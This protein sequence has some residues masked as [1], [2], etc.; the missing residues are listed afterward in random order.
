MLVSDAVV[1]AWFSGADK[2]NRSFV[3]FSQDAGRTFGAP[4]RLDEGGSLGRVD[5]ALLDD[6]SAVASWIEFA[7]G[8]AEFRYRRVSADGRSGPALTVTPM[9]SDRSAG[10]PR[11]AQHGNELVF[12]WTASTPATPPAKGSALQVRTAVAPVPR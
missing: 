6:G 11:L 9:T 4:I 2:Q 8:S 5:V 7:S 1:L 10:Y 12:A 3:A